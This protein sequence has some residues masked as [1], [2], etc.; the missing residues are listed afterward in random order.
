MIE[1]QEII[2]QDNSWITLSFLVILTLI[3]VLRFVYN[4]R[5]VNIST[6]FLSKKYLLIYFTKEKN[7]IQNLFQTSLF[8]IQV[9]TISIL[10]YLSVDLFPSFLSIEKSPKAFISIIVGVVLYFS[11]RYLMGNFIGYIFNLKFLQNKL[12]YEKTNYLNNLILWI[13][14][15]LVLSFYNPANNNLLLSITYIITFILLIMRYVLLMINNKK[16]VFNDLF[17][18]ILYLCALEI[19][20]LVIILKLTI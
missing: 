5:L 8:I 11:F 1:A 13:L 9:L 12:A 17:Y 2:K 16:L 7:S 15:F 18:F 4:E 6:L 19:A 20:P 14:P 10:I 3:A